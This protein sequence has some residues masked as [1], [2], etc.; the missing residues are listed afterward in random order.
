MACDI[1]IQSRGEGIADRARMRIEAPVFFAGQSRD[2]KCAVHSIAFKSTL[3]VDLGR[4]SDGRDV[5]LLDPPKI[6]FG[7]CIG[8][9]KYGARVGPAKDMRYTIRV[10]VDGYIASESL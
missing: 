1:E 4:P 3:A 6:I 5:V 10:T 8:E 2:L 7:L 9:T